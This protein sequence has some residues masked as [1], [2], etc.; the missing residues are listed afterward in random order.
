LPPLHPQQ[1]F[2]ELVFGCG[3]RRGNLLTNSSKR[4][5]IDN[6]KDIQDAAAAGK[7]ENK[8]GCRCREGGD[9]E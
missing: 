9:K 1:V 4:S 8:V 3:C 2:L 7:E 5:P 6:I